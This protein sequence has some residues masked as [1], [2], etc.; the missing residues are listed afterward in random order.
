[1]VLRSDSSGSIP[2][3]DIDR[4]GCRIHTGG[5]WRYFKLVHLPA[6]SFTY[7]PVEPHPEEI[8]FPV[9]MIRSYGLTATG[10]ILA[11]RRAG[12]EGFI[13]NIEV[14]CH[15]THVCDSI[16][17]CRRILGDLIR[18]RALARTEIS[19]G[20]FRLKEVE[21]TRTRFDATEGRILR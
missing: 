6:S 16:S 7:T 3:A 5:S 10:I 2:V 8:T 21:E 9:A 11:V 4:R 13:G 1:M 19:K 14:L 15:N 17:T 12:E 18:G 20:Y